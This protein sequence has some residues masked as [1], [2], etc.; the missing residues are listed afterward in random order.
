MAAFINLDRS[1]SR[2]SSSVI[3]PSGS[4]VFSVI[5]RGR[6]SRVLLGGRSVLTVRAGGCGRAPLAWPG[7]AEERFAGKRQ[8]IGGSGIEMGPG[9]MK[10]GIHPD[11]SGWLGQGNQLPNYRQIFASLTLPVVRSILMINAPALAPSGG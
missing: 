11:F 4:S 5:G 1:S 9:G 8:G 7:L 3:V 6:W 10:T 2:C